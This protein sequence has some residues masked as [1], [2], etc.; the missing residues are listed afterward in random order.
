[1]RITPKQRRLRQLAILLQFEDE[2]LGGHLL[3]F[4]GSQADRADAREQFRERRVTLKAHPQDERVGKVA[5]DALSLGLGAPRD[6]RADDHVIFAAVALHHGRKSG[7]QDHVER[8]V[9]IAARSPQ[10]RQQRGRQHRF[11]AGTGEI[12]C[13]GARPVGRQCRGR[14]HPAELFAPI[15]Q[16]GLQGPRLR[17]GALPG[18]KVPKIDRQRRQVGRFA[19]PVRRVE[20]RELARDDA[21]RPGVGDDVVRIERQQ[22][23]LSAE[24]HEHDAERRFIRQIE[25]RSRPLADEALCFGRTVFGIVAQVEALDRHGPRRLCDRT[26]P[27]LGRNEQRA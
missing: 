2:L 20:L 25:R 26:R 14:G 22:P 19:V 10:L 4:V 18:G 6:R 16:S 1:M 15:S 24:L 11:A 3:V 27:G 8:R 5:D 12:R 9:V 21:L 7:Q 17:G 13:G 23:L